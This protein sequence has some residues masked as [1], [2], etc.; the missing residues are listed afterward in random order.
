LWTREAF[1]NIKMSFQCRLDFFVGV[2]YL[3]AALQLQFAIATA[4]AA[5]VDVA[6]AAAAFVVQHACICCRLCCFCRCT[7]MWRAFICTRKK[8]KKKSSEPQTLFSLLFSHFFPLA[9]QFF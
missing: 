5:A 8:Y 9:L 1:P 6:A 2:V 7:R 3:L 4:V